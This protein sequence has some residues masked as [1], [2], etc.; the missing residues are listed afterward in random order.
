MILLLEDR[1]VA[2]GEKALAG[3]FGVLAVVEGAN[4]DME[5]LVRPRI[6]GNRVSLGPQGTHEQVGVL[7]VGDGGHLN[8]ETAS[9]DC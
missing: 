4:L 2:V 8:Q 6:S 7:F 5:E 9:C 1:L 3:G